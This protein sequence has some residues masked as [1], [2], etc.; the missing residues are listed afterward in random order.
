MTLKVTII[1][2]FRDTSNSADPTKLLSRITFEGEQGNIL[3]NLD[4]DDSAMIMKICVDRLAKIAT[5]TARE[6]SKPPPKLP[7]TPISN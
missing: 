1:N 4:E 7:K 3:I 2:I 6:T 5:D